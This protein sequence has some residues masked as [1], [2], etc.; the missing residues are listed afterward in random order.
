MSNIGYDNQLK[1]SQFNYFLRLPTNIH[2]YVGLKSRPEAAER[3]H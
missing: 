3:V 2:E 1:D